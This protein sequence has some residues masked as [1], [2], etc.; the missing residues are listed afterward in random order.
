MKGCKA[1]VQLSCAV[2]Q[3]Q[4]EEHDYKDVVIEG[5]A[6]TGDEDRYGEKFISGSW[7]NAINQ[8]MS[9]N[10]VLLMDHNQDIDSVVGRVL[11][12]REDAGAKLYM[13][14]LISNA[15]G[16]KDLRYKIKEGFIN[17]VSVAGRWLYEGKSIK[18]VTDLFE[19]SLVAIPANPFALVNSKSFDANIDSENE[20]KLRITK[21]ARP[22]R[23]N[24]TR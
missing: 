12:L 10:P 15:P 19:I 4:E 1:K 9:T 23:I 17:S 8:F 2:K 11:E 13:K 20:N 14:A 18:E 6:S 24:L 16:L 22:Y 5:F 21:N 7:K 3:F